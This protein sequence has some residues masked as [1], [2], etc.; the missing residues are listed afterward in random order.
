MNQTNLIDVFSNAF[1]S[2]D[3]SP[4]KA[5][6]YII[7]Q[8]NMASQETRDA[9]DMTMIALCGYSITSL[10]EQAGA[11]IESPP[12]TQD[13]RHYLLV[14]EGDV[15]PYLV[16]PETGY[17]QVLKEAQDRRKR[18]DNDGLY[19]LEASA[20]DLAVTAFGSLELEDY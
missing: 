3:Q 16:G 18:D 19:Y 1:Y 14:V 8:Y 15:E 9:I 11:L 12:S 20:N 4:E 5:S 7:N 17:D 6:E 10:A 13:N 2:D